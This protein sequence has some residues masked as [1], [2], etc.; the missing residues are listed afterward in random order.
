MMIQKM[1][2]RDTTIE[3]IHQT[4]QQ[5]ADK[6]AGDI[7]AILDDARKRQTASGRAIWRGPSSLVGRR[8]AS[9]NDLLQPTEAAQSVSQNSTTP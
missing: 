9:P 5:M 2:K 8:S 4:R 7:A 6:F 3:E 1:N